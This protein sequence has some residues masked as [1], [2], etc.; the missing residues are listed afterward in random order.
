MKFTETPVKGA[1]LIDLEPNQDDRGFFSRLFCADEF[2]KRGLEGKIL[3]INNSRSRYENTL[4][5]LHY[6]LPPFEET[7]LVRC[8]EGAIFDVVLDLRKDSETYRQWFGDVLSSENRKMLYV[9]RGCAHG[10]ITLTPDSEII[11]FVSENYSK[12]HERGI[13]YNDPAFNIK[14]PRGPEV[15]SDKDRDYP[16]YKV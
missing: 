13:R 5:G 12:E 14:W 1:F 7:K 8:I 6:Q 10:F 16:D 15:I 11:Y 2:T 9:P 4:R 3:Q